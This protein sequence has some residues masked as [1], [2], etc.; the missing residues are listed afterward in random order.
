MICDQTNGGSSDQHQRAFSHHVT[1]DKNMA[2][3]VGRTVSHP[4]LVGPASC[5]NEATQR[6]MI[7]GG[8]SRFCVA[9]KQQEFRT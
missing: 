8:V 4:N 5:E 9:K 3:T 1:P 2:C 7:F 6:P